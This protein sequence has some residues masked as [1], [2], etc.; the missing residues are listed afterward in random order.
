MKSMVLARLAT[1]RHAWL[2]A[3]VALSCKGSGGCPSGG[4]SSGGGTGSAESSGG[5]PP[6][7]PPPPSTDGADDTAGGDPPSPFCLQ[8]PVEGQTRTRLQCS[9]ELHATMT[10]DV[11]VVG[12]GVDQDPV[13]ID[14]AFGSGQP[15]DEYSD[16]LV[17]GCCAEI[18]QPF[19]SSSASQSC[20]L[21]FIETSCQS[22]PVRIDEKAEEQALDGPKEAL[23]D[24]A[25]WI[26]N[27]QTQCRSAFGSTEIETTEPACTADDA[28]A[29]GPLLAGR[30][31][32]I[33]GT[34]SGGSTDIFN[35][36]ITVGQAS[37]TGAHTNAGGAGGP[38]GC[39]SLEDNDGEPH[40]LE[41]FPS[42]PLIESD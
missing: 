25:T 5:P 7:P 32:Q 34:F 23:H 35:V 1:A 38:R 24:L 19:C 28:S 22:L 6:P 36:V 33:P 26:R 40:F 30:Q 41:I 29:Y 4:G 42:G 9:G 15:G 12:I 21:D 11:T 17:M 18:S 10:L 20:Y 31:W 14:R 39:W 2:L 37:V 27:N 13:P 16:P 8:D 3:F